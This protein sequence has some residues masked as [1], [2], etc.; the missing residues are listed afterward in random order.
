MTYLVIAYPELQQNS[1]DWI[2]NYRQQNDKQFSM[3]DPHFTIVFAVNDLDKDVF[4]QEVKRTAEG[5]EPFD[6]DLKVATI[7]QDNSGNYYHEF[8][9]PDGGYSNIVRLHD[10]LY[11]GSLSP[12]RR[13]DVDFIPHISIGDGKTAQ[14]SKERVDA[15]NSKDISIHGR[16]SSLDII[17]YDDG[18]IT[19]VE[20][21]TL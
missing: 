8:L 12:Y 18:V 2:Q 21:V 11:S 3:V 6:F 1:F 13:F 9:V 19:P 15:L 7:N 17:E 10:R 5:F 4:V 14:I 16:I 20:K